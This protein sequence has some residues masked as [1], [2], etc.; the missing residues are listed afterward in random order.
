M[1]PDLAPAWLGDARQREIY[2][3]PMAWIMPLDLTVGRD[4]E[5]WYVWNGEEIQDDWLRSPKA[6]IEETDARVGR[7]RA[8]MYPGSVQRI[9]RTCRLN[10]AGLLRSLAT[11]GHQSLW[12]APEA[13]SI[14]IWTHYAFNNHFGALHET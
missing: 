3:V 13:A 9:G 6:V 12:V 1:G 2:C 7:L 8:V 4:L 5:A 11:Q 10:C 14:S